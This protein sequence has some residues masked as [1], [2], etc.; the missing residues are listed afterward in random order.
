MRTDPVIDLGVIDRGPARSGDDTGAAPPGARGGAGVRLRRWWPLVV[1]SVVLV[2]ST[3]AATPAG[4]GLAPAY[5]IPVAQRTSVALT[6]ETLYV[7]TGTPA[8]VNVEDP[9]F[10]LETYRLSDGGPRWT[11]THEVAN[12][13]NSIRVR[14][15][16]GIPLVTGWR[17]LTSQTGATIHVNPETA[18]YDP[19]TGAQLWTEPGFVV[20]SRAGQVVLDATEYGGNPP[21]PVSYTVTELAVATGRILWSDRLSAGT[22]ADAWALSPD[23]RHLAMLRRDGHLAVRELDTGGESVTHLGQPW[24]DASVTI[25]G[26][27]LRVS[28]LLDRRRT[29][30][31]YDLYPLR[32]QWRLTDQS[33]VASL[34][35]CGP[36]LC[37]QHHDGLRGLDPATGVRRWQAPEGWHGAAP[38]P[39]PW[40]AGQLQVNRSGERGSG[41][42]LVIVDAATGQP[43]LALGPWRPAGPAAQ[44]HPY[45]VVELRGPGAHRPGN[46]EYDPGR[47]WLGR[48]GPD[49]AGV[50]VLGSLD[51]VTECTIGRSHLACVSTQERVEVWRIR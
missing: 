40:P 33:A 49:L 17:M 23:G 14:V 10:W 39:S 43:G 35:P 37:L 27:L 13:P 41:A 22:D 29:L 1:L 11:A 20:A 38:L 15:V 12:R 32:R 3:A 21:G 25:A 31:V 19:D 46:P 2:A 45:P 26:D 16:D 9:V 48:V 8:G 18:A 28:A 7:A 30:A 4:Y 50:E 34:T 36:V 6:A 51:Q 47:L 5:Q 24:Y 42:D 44:H